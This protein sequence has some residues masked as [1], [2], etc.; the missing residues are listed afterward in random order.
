[1]NKSKTKIMIANYN[2]NN[3]EEIMRK[4]HFQNSKLSSD[5]NSIPAHQKT[6][7]I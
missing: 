5:H 4:K 2:I 3:D 1:M 7:E 6:T